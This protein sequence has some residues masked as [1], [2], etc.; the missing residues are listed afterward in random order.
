MQTAFL[1]LKY[2]KTASFFNVLKAFLG[3]KFCK[4]N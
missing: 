3:D 4:S 2:F 1:L